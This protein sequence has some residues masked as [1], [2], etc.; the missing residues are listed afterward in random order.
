MNKLL[1]TTQTKTT[2]SLNRK[3]KHQMKLNQKTYEYY[4]ERKSEDLVTLRFRLAN[5]ERPVVFEFNI[6]YEKINN[7]ITIS[8]IT[9]TKPKKIFI[10]RH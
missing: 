9:E 1:A 2:N 3:Y 6:S 8:A 4:F 5:T 10:D 7:F